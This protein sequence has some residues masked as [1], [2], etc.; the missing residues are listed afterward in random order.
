MGGRQRSFGAM[1]SVWTLVNLKR[2]MPNRGRY[3]LEWAGDQSHVCNRA[4][5]L[6]RSSTAKM[7]F[8]GYFQDNEQ[9][10]PY[11]TYQAQDVPQSPLKPEG[12]SSASPSATLPHAHLA[13]GG[14]FGM[15][16]T[17]GN[18]PLQVPPFL[19]GAHSTMAPGG[20]A[21]VLSAGLITPGAWFN[22]ASPSMS[23]SL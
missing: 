8:S 17:A 16:A 21:E 23:T 14:L 5:C 7:P 6:L 1:G 20:G 12:S 18:I 2:G 10:S 3:I 19:F 9:P 4:S 11:G 22:A 13:A 15:P